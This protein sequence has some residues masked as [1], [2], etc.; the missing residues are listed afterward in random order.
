SLGFDFRIYR[1]IEDI[2][3]RKAK[4]KRT[5][6]VDAGDAAEVMCKCAFRVEVN[7]VATL[8]YGGGADATVENPKIAEVQVRVFAGLGAKLGLGCPSPAGEVFGARGEIH[9]AANGPVRRLSED[10]ALD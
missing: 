6:V 3:E 4:D 10:R 2:V 7:F 1:L 8:V 5:Q 9:A